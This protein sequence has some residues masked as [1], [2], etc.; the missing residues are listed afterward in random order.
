M[1]R[2]E[3]LADAAREASGLPKYSWR[4]A[5]HLKTAS[6][7]A[8]R[9][10][11]RHRWNRVVGLQPAHSGNCPQHLLFISIPFGLSY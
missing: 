7:E 4:E 6:L 1:R 10:A 3:L 8:A 11:N 5:R 9:C 2:G